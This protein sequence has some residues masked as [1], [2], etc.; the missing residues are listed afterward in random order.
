MKAVKRC[1]L[2]FIN[3]FLKGEKKTSPKVGAGS[4]LGKANL[5]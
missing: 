3:I 1:K 2:V 5:R 4:F